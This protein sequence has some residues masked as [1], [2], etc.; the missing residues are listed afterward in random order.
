MNFFF[1]ISSNFLKCRIQIPNFVNR[2]FKSLNLK[3]FK[4]QPKNQSWCLSDLSHKKINEFFFIIENSEIDRKSIY[5]LAD[6]KIYD[7]FNKNELE[8]YNNYTNTSPEYRAN[9]EIYLDGGGFSSYQSEYPFEMTLK[10]GSIVSS[11][12]S[13]S[14]LD[15]DE[16][17]V[18]I[19]NIF[20][21]PIE[22]KYS[23]YFVNYRT[24]KIEEK[25][26]LKT[27][28]INFVKVS[29]NLIKPEI[30]LVTKEYLGIPMY[31]SKKNKHLSFEH[32][33]PPH[34]YIL[35]DNRFLKV[36]DFKKELNAIID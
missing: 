20:Y 13:L 10:K 12:S 14:N 11:V 29:K 1:G 24:K 21:K 36:K 30:F 33:H 34:E 2:K 16:N 19:K 32:T 17:Y 22:E 18:F 15:A 9:L 3:L 28:N 5:F 6:E 35:S 7:N 4:C 25:C 8:N 27:N 26:E 23:L 31:V